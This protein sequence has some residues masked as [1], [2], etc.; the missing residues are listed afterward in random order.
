MTLSPITIGYDATHQNIAHLPP[1]Q[2]AAGYT[3]GSPDIKWTAAD[4]AAHPGALRIDQDFAASD[5]TADYLDVEQ[6]AATDA[7]VAT[8]YK[9]ALASYHNATRPGQRWPGFYTSANNVTPLVNALIAGGVTTGPRLIIANWNLSQPQAAASL[10]AAIASLAA[11]GLT[12]DPFPIAGIQFADPGPY[13]INVYSAAW[14]Q[15]VSAKPPP[16]G[17]YR[18]VADGKHSLAQIA[19]ARNTT[20]THLA[21]V[22]ERAYAVSLD[23]QPLA[24][25]TEFW[26]SNP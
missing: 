6:F 13:D 24:P 1:G 20:A 21:A 4:W 3:T 9:N 10:A 23:A 2:Q 18:H 15:A 11:L 7:E 12:G 16:A 19:A 17:P 25:G 22:S 8:W 26:T 5:F 14:L